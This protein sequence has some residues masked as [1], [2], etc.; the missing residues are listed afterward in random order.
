MKFLARRLREA[1]CAWYNIRAADI[2]PQPDFF[3]NLEETNASVS[4]IKQKD[5]CGTSE[6]T[7]SKMEEKK[8]FHM[9]SAILGGVVL[10]CAGIAAAVRYCAGAVSGGILPFLAALGK[11]LLLPVTLTLLLVCAIKTRGR[12]ARAQ[13]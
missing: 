5:R 6:R 8:R 3:R 13:R 9:F 2:I 7:E 4:S 1:T 10:V 12:S 11:V